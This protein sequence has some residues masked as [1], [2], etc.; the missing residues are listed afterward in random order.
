MAAEFVG[1]RDPFLSGAA[2]EATIT[3]FV[4]ESSLND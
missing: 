1:L 3:P 2:R 4:R